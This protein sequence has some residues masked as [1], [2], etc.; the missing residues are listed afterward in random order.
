MAGL[1]DRPPRWN[2][3]M[4]NGWTRICCFFRGWIGFLVDVYRITNFSFLNPHNYTKYLQINAVRKQTESLIFIEAGTFNGVTAARCSFVFEKVFTIELDTGLFENAS[5]ALLNR[6][7]VTPIHGDAIEELPKLMGRD[8]MHHLLV[9]LDGHYSGGITACGA[10]P[11]PA[12]H[13]LEILS[14]YRNKIEAIIIDDF[15]AFGIDHGYPDKS[16]IIKSAELNFGK[17][18]FDIR[19]HLDQIIIVRQRV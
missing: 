11:E 6:K 10:I 12:R 15:R 1:N 18:G 2:A 14:D 3:Y 16:D 4:S 7:N 5:Q 9:Y 13:E 17:H 8:D 19:V